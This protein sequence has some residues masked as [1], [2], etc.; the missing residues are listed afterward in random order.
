MFWLWT[1][2]C[3]SEMNAEWSNKG[4]GGWFPELYANQPSLT[5][6]S[7][8]KC[9]LNVTPHT[10]ARTHTRPAHA[11]T[12]ALNTKQLLLVCDIIT[13]AGETQARRAAVIAVTHG[14][15]VRRKSNVW[16]CARVCLYVYMLVC[17]G[18]SVS[19]LETKFFGDGAAVFRICCCDF[20]LDAC[21]VFLVFHMWCLNSQIY[22]GG[23]ASNP[24]CHAAYTM[25]F[26]TIPSGVA[27]VSCH[28][29]FTSVILF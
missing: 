5:H 7:E 4:G 17:S 13:P 21:A 25:H 2:I 9:L 22:G 27:S 26:S 20:E 23:W 14:E 15:R 18:D 12:L 8:C 29:G 6:S 24:Y 19:V 28:N 10:H 11:H 1:E 3:R 16:F